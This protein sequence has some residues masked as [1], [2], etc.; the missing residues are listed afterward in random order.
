[1]SRK[2]KILIACG[3][4]VLLAALVLILFWLFRP[5]PPPLV[6]QTAGL[7]NAGFEG[8][9]EPWQGTEERR[10]ASAWQLWYKTDWP[11]EISTLAPPR[12][13]AVSSPRREGER[14]Q[15]LY[16]QDWKNFDACVYQQIEEL[17]PGYYVRFSVWGR[18]DTDMGGHDMQTRIGIDPAGGTDPLAIQYETH[19]QNWSV[20]TAGSGQWQQLEV[21]AKTV[22][23]TVTVYACAHPRWPMRFDVYWDE[24]ALDVNV[25]RLSY[26]PLI[27]RR[28]WDPPVGV[29]FNPDLER[30]WGLLEGYQVP[31]EGYTN[32]YVAPYWMPFWNDDFDPDTGENRQPE[33]NYTDRDY[34]IHAGQ[35]AQQYGLS[36]WGNYEAGIFQVISGT[37]PG[38]TVRFSIWGLGWSANDPQNERYSDVREGLNFRIGIDP[39]GSRSY[40]STQIIWSELYDPYDEWHQF[41]ITATVQSDQISVWAYAHP[42][43]YWARFNQVFWDDAVLEVIDKP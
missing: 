36:A 35:V 3:A 25:E 39:Y 43:A 5:Q 15:H 2:A 24:A 21:V 8:E 1:M 10:I 42:R 6:I 37:V 26:V 28:H 22:G 31:L 33:Y 32:V 12:A 19:P 29:L 11:D 9:Y 20:Y 27:M 16:W 30:D 18:V 23:E 4:A 17:N 40:T 41:E 34:R 7:Q 14:A 13:N 38:E